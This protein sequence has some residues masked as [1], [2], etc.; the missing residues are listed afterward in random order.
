MTALIAV[1][2]LAPLGLAL[3]MTALRS[4]LDSAFRAPL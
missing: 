1:F 2:L 3:P 4:A